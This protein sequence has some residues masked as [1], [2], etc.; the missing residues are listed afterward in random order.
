MEKN[1]TGIPRSY[2]R[3]IEE[4][5]TYPVQDGNIAKHNIVV[6]Y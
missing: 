5:K 4:E 1:T 2:V 6:M 3:S